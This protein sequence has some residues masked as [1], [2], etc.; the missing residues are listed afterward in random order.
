MERLPADRHLDDDAVAALLD[1][2]SSAE[3]AAHL[4]QCGACRDELARLRAVLASHA[5]AVHAATESAE[6][7]LA[8]QR[9]A[10]R[11]RWNAERRRER[12]WRSLAWAAAAGA[13]LLVMG[14]GGALLP[15]AGA[16][17]SVATATPSAADR[18]DA[19]LLRRA[20]LAVGG[21]TPDA[22][23]PV[24]ALLGELSDAHQLEGGV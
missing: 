4:E 6:P 1:G 10:V 21:G 15:G 2:A 13:A 23:A 7:R 16:R 17:H 14:V 8:A 3:L 18:T 22:L 24:E 20:E 12:R 11:T 19:E 5:A 9:S